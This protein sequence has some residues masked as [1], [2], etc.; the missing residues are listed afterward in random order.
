MVKLEEAIQSDRFT[1]EK[2]KAGL[3]LLYTTWWL[4][5]LVSRQLKGFEL[6]QEQFNVLRILKG[7]H[8]DEMCIKDIGCRMIERSS[9]VPRIMDKLV[10]KKLVNR[11]ISTIDKRE[12]VVTLTEE[13]MSL[14]D[15]ARASVDQIIQQTIPL[16]ETE[17]AQLNDLLEKVRT[18]E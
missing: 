2:Q 11:S 10:A 17:A 3:N 5:T 8:P 6:T 15:Q 7:R 1:S 14:V 4:K 12:T 16:N 13:G 9:N 18:K